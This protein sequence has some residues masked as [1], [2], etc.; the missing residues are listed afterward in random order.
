MNKIQALEQTIY[1][2][3]NDVY[4]YKWTEHDH[5]N[6]GILATTILNGKTPTQ[7]GYCNTPR[8][9]PENLGA[10]SSFSYCMT[11]DLPLPEVF[12]A[13]KDSG[14]SHQEIHELE[15]LSNI[16]ICKLGNVNTELLDDLAIKIN[17]YRSTKSEVIKYLKGWMVLLKSEIKPEILTQPSL[18]KERIKY[19]LVPES[20]S[21]QA[22]ETILTSEITS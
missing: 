20:L 17:V 18:I 14:F 2:L 10:F 7:A 21:N 19:V 8:I 12:Q 16:K 3:E 13:L 22:K 9:G 11:T 15:H 5:C 6:C 1:N 4:R